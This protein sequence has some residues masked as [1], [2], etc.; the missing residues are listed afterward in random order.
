MSSFNELEGYFY[1]ASLTHYLWSEWFY[2]M[3]RTVKNSN[4]DSKREF[5]FNHFGLFF[6]LCV[7][8]SQIKTNT[9]IEL[10]WCLKYFPNNNLANLAKYFLM[11][12]KFVIETTISISFEAK[13]TEQKPFKDFQILK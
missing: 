1:K 9:C 10:F 4:N 11:L 5:F 2:V 8:Y 7:D 13:H 12:P 6:L 3:P